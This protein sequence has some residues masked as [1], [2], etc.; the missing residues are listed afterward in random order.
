LRRDDGEPIGLFE[1]L[2]VSESSTYQAVLSRLAG[3]LLDCS[4]SL[5]MLASP[6]DED[7]LSE[8]ALIDEIHFSNLIEGEEIAIEDIRTRLSGELDAASSLNSS[9]I[10]AANHIKAAAWADNQPSTQNLL[11]E[12]SVLAVHLRL[13]QDT[14]EYHNSI[15]RFIPGN[16]RQEDVIVGE[17]IPISPSAIPR[18]IQR[19]S[20]AYKRGTPKEKILHVAYAHHRF[21]WVHPFVDGNGRVARFLTKKMLENAVPAARYWSLSKEL[22]THKQNYLRHLASCDKPRQGDRDGRGNLSEAALAEF[23]EFVLKLCIGKTRETIEKL[24]AR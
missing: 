13:F 8:K 3:E 7:K 2:N 19:L 12:S 14:A 16:F 9:Q 21:V 24:E 4:H 6:H 11:T 22:Y 20:E 5:K 18:F 17:H 1:P 15:D 10:L 23:T